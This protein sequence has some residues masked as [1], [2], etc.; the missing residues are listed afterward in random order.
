VRVISASNSNRFYVCSYIRDLGNGN[1]E[2]DAVKL[3]LLILG[4]DKKKLKFNIAM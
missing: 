2:I 4:S 1:N 3:D